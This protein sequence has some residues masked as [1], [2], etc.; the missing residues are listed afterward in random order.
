MIHRLAALPA[1]VIFPTF[2]IVGVGLTL[3]FDVLMRR[4]VQPETRSRASSTASVTLQVTAT[5]YA[6]LIAFVIVDAYNDVQATQ[7]EISTK[8]S[9]LAIIYE[10][11]R[12]FEPD[13]GAP[14]RDA[15]LAYADAV[16]ARGIPR[17]ED[18]GRPDPGT[19]AR[20]EELFRVV[21]EMHPKDRADQ[22]AYDASVR[23]LD[24]IVGTRAEL[25]D[26]ARATVPDALLVLLFIIGLVVM[27]LGTLLDTQHRRS[28]LVILSALALVVWLTLALVVSLDSAFDG[29][30]RVSDQPIRDFVTFRAAR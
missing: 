13:D 15:T 29:V 11:S 5:I 22:A 17:L 24:G 4:W 12:A 30:I 19:D 16:L 18:S 6:I 3:L 21:Q 7:R 28:H 10:N 14:V 20:L 26:S 9:N 1:Y 25:L 2:V 27:G 8:A 23:A